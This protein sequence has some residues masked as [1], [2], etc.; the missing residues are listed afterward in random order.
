MD[1]YRL[2]F[3]TPAHVSSPFYLQY[4]NVTSDGYIL[5]EWHI[6]AGGP[7]YCKYN[8]SLIER[9]VGA[10]VNWSRRTGIPT[11][12]GAWRP[13]WVPKKEREKYVC[14]T[15]NTIAFSKAMVSALK[16]AGIPYDINA[17]EWFFDIANLTWYSPGRDVL[18]VILHPSST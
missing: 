8:M 15:Q 14:S 17:D 4:L 11:W 1:P 18:R 10:A 12:V 3:V 2:I 6:Y 9:A 16:G 5:A 7:K 13:Y